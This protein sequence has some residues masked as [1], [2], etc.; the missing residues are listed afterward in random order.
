MLSIVIAALV[1]AGLA[2]ILYDIFV[3]Y[4]LERA[5]KLAENRMIERIESGEYDHSLAKLN[6]DLDF[7]VIRA[8]YE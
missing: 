8:L 6:T 3:E 1:V 2:P 4:R 7:E 5:Y